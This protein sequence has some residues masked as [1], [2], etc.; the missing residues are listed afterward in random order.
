MSVRMTVV[1]LSVGF[2]P[3]YFVAISV[4]DRVVGST[5]RSCVS[6]YDSSEL[7][8]VLI[9]LIKHVRWARPSSSAP[10]WFGGQTRQTL[11][12][13]PL[14]PFVDK[15]PAH[16]NPGGN[17]GDRHPISQEYNHLASSGMPRRDG[18]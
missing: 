1:I 7:P 18:L 11:L 6:A 4:Y 10:S 12:E 5:S 13:E 8:Y 17:L 14:Y 15:A 16:P 2:F 3:G 9:V